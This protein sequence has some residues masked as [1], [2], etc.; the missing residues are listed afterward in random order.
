M[1]DPLAT[2]R[3]GFNYSGA[4]SLSPGALEKAL[5]AA[6]GVGAGPGGLR[7]EI[8]AGHGGRRI[9]SF[10]WSPETSMRP[11]PGAAWQDLGP[12]LAMAFYDRRE[13]PSY[14]IHRQ[15]DLYFTSKIPRD[16]LASHA[17]RLIVRDDTA[18]FGLALE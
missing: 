2:D 6:R 12:T 11:Q 13:V 18:A 15:G 5:E 16:V 3:E 14:A 17:K 1:N 10:D 7:V 9:I 8:G 4:V